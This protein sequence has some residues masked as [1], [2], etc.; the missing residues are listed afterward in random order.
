GAPPAPPAQGG[1]ATTTARKMGGRGGLEA[2]RAVKTLSF[3][4]K[5]DAGGKQHT[6]LPFVLEMKRPRKKRVEIEFENE[7]AIQVY[8]GAKGWKLRPYLGRRD[9]EPFSAE[10]L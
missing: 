8:D 10:E 7:K 5:M 3:S 6:Q 4:G 9:V 1:P 2:W